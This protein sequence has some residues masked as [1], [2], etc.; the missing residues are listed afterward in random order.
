MI[1]QGNTGSRAESQLDFF[2]LLEYNHLVKSCIC[3]ESGASPERCRHRNL[4]AHALPLG[5][6]LKKSNSP[7]RFLGRRM[8]AVKRSRDTYIYSGCSF[9]V[10]EGA[11]VY[12]SIRSNA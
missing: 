11:Y 4:G 12:A 10:H 5:L 9:A 6:P 3:K 7:A 2:F 1:C 8:V